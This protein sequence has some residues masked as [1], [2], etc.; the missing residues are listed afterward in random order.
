MSDV[1]EFEGGETPV[2][3]LIIS[4]Y[5]N[6]VYDKHR[7][8]YG[9]EGANKTRGAAKSV[10]S[11]ALVQETDDTKT[12][13][14]LLVGKVQS[15]KTSNLEALVGLALDSGFNLI[16][17]YGGYDNTLLKQTVKRFRKTMD[18]P[19][20]VDDEDALW[21]PAIPNIFTTDSTDELCINNLNADVIREFLADGIPVFII[22]IK[23]ARRIKNINEILRKVRDDSV[24]SLVIDDEGD[25][26]S[27]N[28]VRDKKS[29]A[30][31]TYGAICDMKAVLN[32]PI[33]FSVTATPQANI[34][35]NALSELRPSAVHLLHPSRGY[36]GAEFFH[37][38]DHA[39]IYTIPDEMDGA[40]EENRS[41]ASLQLAIRHFVLASAILRL[42]FGK[43]D[44]A[45][46][47]MV[48]HAYREVN[49]H[50]IIYQWV[51]AY[52]KDIRDIVDISLADG[53]DT[54]LKLFIDV[55]ENCFSEEVKAANPLN[56][57]LLGMVATVLKETG[58][59]LHNGCD[60][61]TREIVR[62]K[63]HQIY[64]GAQLLERG[65]TFDHLL[66]TYFTRWPKSSDGNMDTNLQ[67]AR[68]F[69][70]RKQY[71]DLIKLFTTETIAVEFSFLAGM[72]DDLWR[73][74]GE[75]E[76]GVLPISEIVVL[77][78]DSKQKPTRR[79]V[80]D[81]FSI[82]TREW[83][84]QRYRTSNR[85]D[86]AH[87]NKCVQDFLNGLTFNDRSYARKDNNRSCREAFCT[88]A[89]AAKFMQ[90]LQGIYVDDAFSQFEVK[91]VLGGADTIAVLLMTSEGA[92]RHRSFYSADKKNM[93]KALHQGRS[94]DGKAY[95]GDKNVISD[96]TTVSLQIFEICP[97]IDGIAL[98]D[99]TQYMFAVYQ[100]NS[101][102]S[103]YVGA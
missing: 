32:D 92:P 86:I 90:E 75:V 60:R 47:Q 89:C 97:E 21:D 68:W 31:A 16:V 28:N 94:E 53:D 88:G 38:E 69:G 29:N 34:F 5:S 78:E 19:T 48:I 35:L 12:N 18:A 84:K 91:K 81:Y 57:A 65:I 83:L 2:P 36:C 40:V 63:R 71:C 22:T 46:T 39:V 59:A 103:G 54:G 33:Y 13:N 41:P 95:L 42:Q 26:A 64:I 30:S 8:S 51:D 15:G 74:F 10:L 85:E 98:E 49:T 52:V 58:I 50:S 61:G 93:I 14:V 55:Y 73:Q 11:S 17:M 27:L 25:Q 102:K 43:R 87:N 66:T 80:A 6:K 96:S 56:D 20:D 37:V 67:R 99:E 101:L 44:R 100:A 23:D 4:D 82:Y 72:E 76:E 77:A 3:S 79:A 62:F 9:D 45:H 1:Y 70:Y 7:Q 24:R